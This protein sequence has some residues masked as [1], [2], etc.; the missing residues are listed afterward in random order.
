MKEHHLDYRS[1]H[2]LV[3]SRPTKEPQVAE[4]QVRTIF[5]E[6]WSEIDHAVRYPVEQCSQHAAHMLAVLN[7]IAGGADEIGSCVRNIQRERSAADAEATRKAG[8]NSGALRDAVKL[9]EEHELPRSIRNAMKV[10][11]ARVPSGELSS[12]DWMKD[13]VSE[14]SAYQRRLDIHAADWI[15]SQ[16]ELNGST[17]TNVV[18]GKH[19]G[20]TC[21]L[22]SVKVDDVVTI[23]ENESG[24]LDAF[25]VEQLRVGRV[26]NSSPLDYDAYCHALKLVFGA[27]PWR[28]R[29]VRV[30]PWE[31]RAM[32]RLMWL[33][34]QIE[35][36]PLPRP[37]HRPTSVR[38][39]HVEST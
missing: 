20:T 24:G 6:G 32:G 5:E 29:V 26:Q 14:V 13:A 31:Q 30:Y 18:C 15:R 16:H 12:D 22:E 39:P 23:S 10:V 9:I 7:R 28:A 25:S 3:R 2:Y 34:V 19:Y 37:A 38:G 4:I 1:V 35:N 33:N 17:R 8:G 21:D 27:L 36:K 11:L